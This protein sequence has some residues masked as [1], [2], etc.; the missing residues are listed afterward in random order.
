MK[1]E[2]TNKNY[3]A[4]VISIKNLM[5]LENCD[6]VV[7]LPIYW[8]QAIVGK[9]SKIGDLWILFTAESQLSTHYCKANNLYRDGDMNDDTKQK[10]YIEKN[11]RVKAIRFRWHTSSALF[12]PLDSLSYLSPS[13][14]EN[15]KEW[16][17]FD[18]ID[19]TE[20]C[21]KY[22]IPTNENVLSNKIRGKNKAWHKISNLT[23]PEHLDSSNY[24]RNQHL[25]K[26]GDEII[27]TQKLHWTSGRWGNLM[28]ELKP[29]MASKVLK[30]LWFNVWKTK[31][32]SHYGSRRVIKTGIDKEEWTSY[33]NTDL[34]GQVNDSI[35]HLIPENWIIYGEIIGWSGWSQI[36]KN[37]TYKINPWNMLLFVYR[38]AIVNQQWISCDLSWDNVM[39]FCDA[40]W[41]NYTPE[42]WRWKKKEFNVDAYMNKKYKEFGFKNAVASDEESPCD[43]WVCIRLEWII[44]YIAKAKCSKFLEHETKELDDWVADIESQ[45]S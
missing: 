31:Y 20:I 34:W 40:N 32:E 29:T 11:R 6:N 35:K 17:S 4:T 18:T 27:V 26:D 39:K 7:W 42:L 22:V 25:I 8:Y 23:F 10:G 33:Y 2:T 37:Y 24:W 19:G 30:F 13:V 1:L 3:A 44:P 12:M 36:Q 15:L 21:R 16:D 41:L 28:S 38:I 14:V 5:T 45:E 9:D 43:E